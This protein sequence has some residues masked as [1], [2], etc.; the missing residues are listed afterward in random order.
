M[1]RP[2]PFRPHPQELRSKA[3]D[4]TDR[5]RWMYLTRSSKRCDSRHGATC[6]SGDGQVLGPDLLTDCPP[7][8]LRS[9]TWTPSLSPWPPFGSCSA[10]GQLCQRWAIVMIFPGRHRP[11]SAG[12]AMECDKF[13]PQSWCFGE[14]TLQ[15]RRFRVIVVRYPGNFWTGWFLESLETSNKVRNTMLFEVLLRS[16][17]HNR[18]LCQTRSTERNQFMSGACEDA[19]EDDTSKGATVFMDVKIHQFGE[20]GLVID[21]MRINSGIICSRFQ[22]L[23]SLIQMAY[24]TGE[25]VAVAWRFQDQNDGRLENSE[26]KN[27][28][29][30]LTAPKMLGANLQVLTWTSCYGSVPEHRVSFQEVVDTLQQALQIAREFPGCENGK[31]FFSGHRWST[32]VCLRWFGLFSHYLNHHL[33]DLAH[34]FQ[35]SQASPRMYI[36]MSWSLVAYPSAMTAMPPVQLHQYRGGMALTA[37]CWWNWRSWYL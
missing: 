13:E 22:T 3:E 34:F 16:K 24:N 9:P 21:Q 5:G 31:W 30:G 18:F 28:I 25:T 26:Q 19:D 20:Y 23:V 2:R 8:G 32:W 27:S 36:Q 6:S 4:E 1:G 35:V 17:K 29:N 10:T 7:A 37:R 15:F 12:C 11:S 33:D 14:A